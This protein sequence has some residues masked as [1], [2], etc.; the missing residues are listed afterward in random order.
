MHAAAETVSQTSDRH[1]PARG[2]TDRG[3][4]MVEIL[5]AI[6]LM[7]SLVAGLLSAVTVSVGASGQHRDLVAANAWLQSGGAVLEILGKQNCAPDPQSVR[8]LYEQQLRLESQSSL[9]WGPSQISITGLKFWNPGVATYNPVT[10]LTDLV[11]SGFVDECTSGA[12]LVTVSVVNPSGEIIQS[13]DV[14][15]TDPYVELDE[16]SMNVPD[17]PST[18]TLESY[19]LGNKDGPFDPQGVPLKKP[20]AT[21]PSPVVKKAGPHITVTTS[22]YCR[23]Q[24]RMVYAWPHNCHDPKKASKCHDHTRRVKLKP[25]KNQPGVYQG[26][27]N[28]KDKWTVTSTVDLTFEEHRPRTKRWTTI[29][30]G[31]VPSGMWFR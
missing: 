30:G 4:S 28:K 13:I 6:V 1:P 11:G 14:V 3:F 16:P 5:I 9:D 15:V 10:G 22:G 27:L 17:P 29:T 2:R 18:C 23:G 12:H 8:D 7:G 19:T 24:L 26:K 25:V 20:S 31:E 21:K